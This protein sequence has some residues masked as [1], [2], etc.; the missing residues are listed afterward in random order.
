MCLDIEHFLK[1]SLI[2][3]I[4]DRVNSGEE[5]DGY[6]IVSDYISDA[7]QSSIVEKA[8]NIKMR[9]SKIASKLNQNVSNPYC[10]NLIAKY[11]SEMPIW[12]L[13]EVISFGDLLDIINYCIENYGMTLP[14]DRVCLDRVRQIRN[15]TAHNNCIINDLRSSKNGPKTPPFITNYVVSAKIG[16]NMRQ[17]KL[18]NPRIN[19]IVHLFWAYKNIVTSEYTRSIRIKELQDLMNN[20]IVEHKEYFHN[21]TLLTSTYDFFYKLVNNF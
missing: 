19:Q 12:A 3:F 11:K 6:K 21:N 10:G 8:N 17:K 16:G 1:V 20:R 7:N 13:V 4:E 15:A 18:S 9:S 2:K 14:V 5:E